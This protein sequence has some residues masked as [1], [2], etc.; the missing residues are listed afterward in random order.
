MK[1]LLTIIPL[2]ILLCF[3]F[4]CQKA[5]EVAEEVAE[6]AMVAA[7]TDED[8]EANRI[9]TAEFAKA[10]TAMDW[11]AVANFY[12]EDA[13]VMPPN[14]PIIQGRDAIY[15]SKLAYPP[16]LGFNAQVEDVYGYGDLAVVRGTYEITLQP[17]GVP[18]PIKDTGKWIE[19]RR[20]QQDGSWLIEIDIWNSNNPPLPPPKKE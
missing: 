17:E 6:E 20:K 18:D 2:V 11:I 7:L 4:G 12:A 3:T 10:A 14:Q 8:V 1:N 16:V 15:S 5:E 9:M 19:I 13:I